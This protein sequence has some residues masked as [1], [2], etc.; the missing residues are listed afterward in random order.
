MPLS[1][2]LHIY[3]M[4]NSLFEQRSNKLF[5][6][7]LPINHTSMYSKIYDIRYWIIRKSSLTGKSTNSPFIY[8]IIIIL[9]YIILY[10]IILYY[11]IE[12]ARERQFTG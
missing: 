9:Y 2:K 7:I 4:L 10:Y 12:A 6:D 3:H 11:I 5:L 8:I 1:Y